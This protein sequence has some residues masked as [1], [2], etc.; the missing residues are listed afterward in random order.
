[1]Y[2]CRKTRVAPRNW[3]LEDCMGVPFGVFGTF[4]VF[5]FRLSKLR[6]K[7]WEGVTFPTDPSTKIPIHFQ[8]RAP[9]SKEAMELVAPMGYVEKDP[10]IQWV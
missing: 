4:S 10:M 9:A 6:G 1:M 7:R 5:F 3:C 2:T 8:G